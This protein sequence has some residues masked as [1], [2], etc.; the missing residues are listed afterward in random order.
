MRVKFQRGIAAAS[1]FAA[2]VILVNPASALFLTFQGGAPAHASFQAA[3]GA[4]NL[5]TFDSYAVGTQISS[6]PLLG[7]GFDE[8]APGLYPGDYLHNVD[9]TP[10][11]PL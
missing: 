11:L 3:S 4:T 10:S 5:G 7:I 9:N 6:L 8:I 1:I 2:A